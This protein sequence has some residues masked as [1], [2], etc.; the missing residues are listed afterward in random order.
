MRWTALS[1]AIVAAS[2][3]EAPAVAHHSFAMFDATKPMTMTGADPFVGMAP[4]D[5]FRPNYYYLSGKDYLL[6]LSASPG[7]GATITAYAAGDVDPRLLVAATV[8]L[9]DVAAVLAGERPD[10]AGAGPKIHV[11]PRSD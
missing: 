5:Q 4:D 1:L 6:Y 9:D 2:A 11:D 8:G 10:G 3:F 7:L